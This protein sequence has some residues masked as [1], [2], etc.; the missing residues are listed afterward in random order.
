MPPIV[1]IPPTHHIGPTQCLKVVVTEPPTALELFI[2]NGQL[3]IRNWLFEIVS[4]FHTLGET[5]S[6]DEKEANWTTP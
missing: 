2:R 6:L 3:V 4:G 5:L 1:P